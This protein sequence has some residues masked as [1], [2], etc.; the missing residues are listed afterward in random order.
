MPIS[1]HRF[2]AAVVFFVVGSAIGLVLLK[3]IHGGVV[4]AKAALHE[5]D[6]ASVAGE[7]F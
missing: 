4:A 1:D 2:Q 6:V 7:P 3:R 5:D